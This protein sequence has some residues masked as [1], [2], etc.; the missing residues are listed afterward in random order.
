ME[1]RA[2]PTGQPLITSQIEDIAAYVR[3]GTCILFLGAGV[4][5]PAPEGSIYSYPD[6][7]RPPFGRELAA[8]LAEKVNF[9]SVFPSGESHESLNLQRV[10]LF[11]ELEKGR[12]QLITEIGS[13]IREDKK[14]SSVL[15]ALANLNFPLVITTNYDLLFDRALVLAEKEPVV[16]IY[17]PE[18]V[19]VS[20]FTNPTSKRPFVLKIHG[21]ISR[22][23]SIVITDEDYIQFV[24]RMGDKDAHHPVPMTFRYRFTTWPT[25]FVGYSLMDYNLRLLFKTLRW[26]IDLSNVPMSYSV[27]HSPDPL[28]WQVW[29]RRGYVKFIAQ[30]VWTFLPQLYQLVTGEEMPQ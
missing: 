15:R 12:K 18:P 3:Q 30:N 29:D 20:D 8:R 24:L 1:E 9:E 14:P 2:L 7:D 27:D 4:H 22:P 26:K 21:D 25:L 13:A 28:I 10:S 5:S 17:N 23:E 6:A 16:S 19:P 11:Y